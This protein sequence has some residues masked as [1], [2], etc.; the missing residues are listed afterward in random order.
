MSVPAGL[1][2]PQMLPVTATFAPAFAAY[3]VL[4]NLRVSVVRVS[5]N[6]MMG[7]TDSATKNSRSSASKP[8]SSKDLLV[9]ARCHANFVENVPFALLVASLVEIN[10]GDRR[11]LAASL[12]ALLFFRIA[13]VEVGLRAK[14]SMGW[15]RPVGYFGT[16]GFVAGMSS[17]AAWLARS[18]WSV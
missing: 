4:L 14:E 16:L 18:Y 3:Y 8:D 15:G 9:S 6:T 2:V 5:C 13:H 10:G 7:A 1:P 12:A 11:V 17:Y